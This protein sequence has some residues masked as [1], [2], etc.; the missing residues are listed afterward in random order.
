MRAVV[1]QILVWAQF[2]LFG[3][4]FSDVLLR[5]G[6][7]FSFL[8]WVVI[9]VQFVVCVVAVVVLRD[10]RKGRDASGM[11]TQCGHSLTGNTSGVCP[12]CGVVI[13]EKTKC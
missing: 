8:H 4:V 11:C 3:V 6:Y 2:V 7:S 5:P 12:E 9:V 1:V 13:P 10:Q